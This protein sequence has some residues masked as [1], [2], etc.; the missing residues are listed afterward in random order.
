MKTAWS[1][2]FLA[3]AVIDLVGCGGAQAT[4]L[5]GR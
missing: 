5:A 1:K 4:G 2:L 3:A